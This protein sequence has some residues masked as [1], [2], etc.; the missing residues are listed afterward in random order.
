[1]QL[2]VI[3]VLKDNYAYLLRDDATNTT[4]VIDPSEADPILKELKKHS[5]MLTH[6][7]NTHHHWDH[8]DGNVELKQQTSCQVIG[9]K[10]DAHRIPAID[11]TWEDKGSYRLGRFHFDVRHTPGHTL[12]QTLLHVP[13]LNALF[14]GDTLF[15]LGCGRLFEGTPAQL[16]AS[17]QTIATYPDDVKLY[18]GHEYTLANGAFATMVEPNNKDLMA[19]LANATTLREQGLPTIPTT[20]GIEKRCNPFL[21]VSNVDDFARLRTM[22]DRF[23]LS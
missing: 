4:I 10:G 14:C 9:Y 11:E 8:T 18:C 17:L 3:P 13:E 5:W 6:I 19:Y 22:K 20:V 12:G 1:M 2:I 15:S 7:I 21:R 16:F 23:K